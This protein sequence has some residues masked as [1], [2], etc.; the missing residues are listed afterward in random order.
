M[1]HLWAEGGPLD[2]L[3]ATDGGSLGIWQQWAPLAH[4]QAVKGGHFFP[5]ENANDTAALIRQ[6]LAAT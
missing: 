4:G 5:E 1:L 3:Y 2:T 6:F